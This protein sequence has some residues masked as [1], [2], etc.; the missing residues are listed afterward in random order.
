MRNNILKFT[1]YSFLDNL[2]FI[3]MINTLY[4]L[5]LNFSFTNIGLFETI[6]ALILVLFELPTGA[7]SDIIGRKKAMI[8]SCLLNSIGFIGIGLMTL[9]TQYYLIAII[10]GIAFSFNSGSDIALLYDSI[11]YNKQEKQYKKIKGRIGVFNQIAAFIGVITGPLL[12]SINPRLGFIATGLI[13]LFAGL[14]VSTMKEPIMTNRL[15]LTGHWNK[16]ISSLVFTLRKKQ[17]LWLIGFFFLSTIGLEFFNEF[18]QQPLL[19]RSGIAIQSFSIIFPIFLGLKALTSYYTHKVSEWLEGKSILLILIIHIICY[20]LF[21]M[22]NK[23]IVLMSFGLFYMI[24]SFQE[25][26]FEDYINKVI[27]SDKRA[28]VLSIK[29]LIYNLLTAGL[30]VLAGGLIDLY[31]MNFII[32]STIFLVAAGSVILF[33]FSGLLDKEIN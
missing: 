2:R 6:F 8:I 30:Y 4:L 26:V 7:L 3:W 25:I 18:W 27:S 33:F 1:I 12:F 13:Y 15:T 24:I 19:I 21:A 14:I 11:K 9:P 22:N 32:V 29:S 16:M 5:W 20:S 23:I 28:T 10:L 31:S 17:I